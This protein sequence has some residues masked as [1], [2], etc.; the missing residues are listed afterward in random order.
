MRLF[1][2]LIFSSFLAYSQDAITISGLLQKE[3][4]NNPIENAILIIEG[5]SENY[6]SN[7]KGEF[8]L[9]TLLKGNYTLKISAPYFV[10]KRL[11]LLIEDGNLDLGIILLKKDITVEKID[12]L[13]TLTESD[14]SV[15]D[16]TVSLSTGLLQATRDVFLNRAAFD[17]GQAF[18]R[19][20][21]YDS[22][23]GEVLINGIR[24]NK[25][26]DGRPQWNNWGGLNDII[27]NQEFTNGLAPS[28]Y[29]FGGVLGNTNIDTRPSNLR[30]GIRLSSSASNRTYAGRLMTTVTSPINSDGLALSLIHI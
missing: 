1:L 22:S 23:N 14:L 15:D 27:R 16:E 3:N 29:T 20:R 24:M 18:F 19:V 9:S 10:T 13:I 4:S 21:G 26:F 6:T 2:V 11:P 25:L 17:F 7:N 5:T 28:D 12:N 30:P 8:K